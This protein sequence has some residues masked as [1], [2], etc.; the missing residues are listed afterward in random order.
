MIGNNGI[1]RKSSINFLGVMLNKHIF[2][3]D[4]RRT[5]GN[6]IAENIGFLY[7]TS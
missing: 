5:V 4:N 3:V 1:E 7:C 6:K 2:W